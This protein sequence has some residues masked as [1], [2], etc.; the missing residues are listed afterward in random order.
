M[1]L[2]RRCEQ[3]PALPGP[4]GPHPARL[5]RNTSGPA[6]PSPARLDHWDAAAAP[7]AAAKGV[8]GRRGWRG[9][10]ERWEV[11]RVG[12]GGGVTLRRA[13][14]EPCPPPPSPRQAA[15][16]P[17]RRSEAG[18]CSVLTPARR[19]A[20]Q[21]TYPHAA[22]QATSPHCSPAGQPLAMQPQPQRHHAACQE[23]YPHRATAG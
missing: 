21:E 9:R 14:A 13:A 16:P 15:T 23:T 7:A 8:G 20:W 4:A 6:R 12:G 22:C 2:R 3:N 10:E 17:P 1:Q 5:G 19:P 11:G 18:E